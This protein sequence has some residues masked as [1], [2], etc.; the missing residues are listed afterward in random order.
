MRFKYGLEIYLGQEEGLIPLHHVL[1]I[2]YFNVGSEPTLLSFI[3]HESFHLFLHD[4][5]CAFLRE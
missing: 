4:V 1:S 5:H 2:F 3:W